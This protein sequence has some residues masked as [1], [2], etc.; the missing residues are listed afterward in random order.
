LRLGKNTGKPLSNLPASFTLSPEVSQAKSRGTP[1]LAL[2]SAVITHGL[3]APINLHT[4]RELEQIA[5][6]NKVTPATIA[7]LEGKIRIGLTAEQLTILASGDPKINKLSTRDLAGSILNGTSG[8]TT[9]AA[10]L[11]CASQVGIKVFTT[12]GIGGVHRGNAN[13]VSADL[14][15]LAHTP[16]IVVCAGAK[17]I[18]DLAATLEYLETW[19]V[20][21]IGYQTDEFPAFFSQSSG[22]KVN[23]RMDNIE[24][25]VQFSRIHWDLG[26][27]SAILVTVQPPHEL[28]LSTQQ[29]DK[30]LDQA[31]REAQDHQVHG[32]QVTPFLLNRLSALTGGDSLRANI[33]LLR[34]NAKIGSQIARTMQTHKRYKQI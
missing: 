22:L 3:P 18:L 29:V 21:V 5:H 11:A 30:A 19:G 8:G 23:Q 24:E 7:V 9:V 20:P 34:R 4:A 32:Q 26:S 13:D 28:A 15:Q 12:G 6:Q 16:M 1:I 33:G 14:P 17:A 27:E 31:I 25:I 10:T 2:E